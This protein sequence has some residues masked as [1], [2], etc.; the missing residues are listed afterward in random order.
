MKRVVLLLLA[1]CASA[2]AQGPT[3]PVGLWRTVDDRT[4]REA[5]LVR[6]YEVNGALYGRIEKIFDPARAGLTCV[7]CDDDRKNKPLVGLDFMRGLR[8]D[9]NQWDG[10]TILDPETGSIYKASAHLGD[11]GRTLV[12]RGYLGISLLGRSQTWV[13]EP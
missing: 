2:S 8:R 9:G 1:L 4:G 10:G 3:S 6:L 5:A 11:G 7:K 13:R 12:V